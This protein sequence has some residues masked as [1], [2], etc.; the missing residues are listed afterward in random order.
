MRYKQKK[1]F[2]IVLSLLA[3]ICFAS[4][5]FAYAANG[6]ISGNTAEMVIMEIQPTVHEVT[7]MADATNLVARFNGNQTV[8]FDGIHFSGP[9]RVSLSFEVYN[10]SAVPIEVLGISMQNMDEWP[11]NFNVLTSNIASGSIMAPGVK[12]TVM[13]DVSQGPL[14]NS[15]ILQQETSFV[16]LLNY[17]PITPGGPGGPGDPGGN[18][19]SGEDGNGES[20]PSLPLERPSDSDLVTIEDGQVPLDALEGSY[21]SDVSEDEGIYLDDFGIPLGTLEN[22]EYIDLDDAAI[23][24]GFLPQ[25]GLNNIVPLMIMG[26][27]ISLI[28]AAA[29]LFFILKHKKEAD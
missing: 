14:S 5:A 11:E 18:G 12:S 26:F 24:L 17:R 4:G 19:G 15:Y 10:I 27:S 7:G 9:G 3:C 8:S 25:T 16:A 13:F 29:A 6:S 21:V 20:S 22:N 28:I 23:P 2:T 1:R